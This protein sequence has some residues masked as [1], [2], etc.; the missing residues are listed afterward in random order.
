MAAD[1]VL[2]YPKGEG[3]AY[4]GRVLL[5]LETKLAEHGELK[6]EDICADDI[7]RVEVM[8]W[9]RSDV[10]DGRGDVSQLMVSRRR[11]FIPACPPCSV[12]ADHGGRGCAADW[13]SKS[14]SPTSHKLHS[15]MIRTGP[16][17]RGS[18]SGTVTSSAVADALLALVS[19]ELTFLFHTHS[20]SLLLC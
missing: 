7:L 1:P 3:V 17:Q 13:L 4:R 15:A 10:G 18:F 16:F 11:A 14:S 6:V 12:R 9:L 20:S 5:E 8:G 2:L 19:S